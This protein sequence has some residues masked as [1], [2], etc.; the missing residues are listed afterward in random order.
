MHAYQSEKFAHYFGYDFDGSNSS[1]PDS[2]N[3]HVYGTNAFLAYFDDDTSSFDS[4]V[5]N[6]LRY[7]D[8]MYV[9]SQGYAN[10]LFS[11]LFSFVDS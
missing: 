4:D 8:I 11:Q 6:L 3:D 7:D 10:S 5:D 9:V 1:P 2:F